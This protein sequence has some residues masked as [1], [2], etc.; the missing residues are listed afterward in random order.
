MDAFAVKLLASACMLVDHI[1]AVFYMFT[2]AF[3]RW[4][5]RISM[6]LYV[7]LIAQGCAKTG[8]INRY[9][10]RLGVFALLS[11]IPFDLAFWQGYYI[12]E[13]RPPAI[14]FLTNT[15]IFYT[16]FFG[17]ACVNVYENARRNAGAYKIF[18]HSVLI[19]LKLR[20]HEENRYA[21]SFLPVLLFTVLF[22]VA[23]FCPIYPKLALTF[24]ILS[25]ML[26]SLF[27]WPRI[28]VHFNVT[29]EAPPES[30]RLADDAAPEIGAQSTGAISW[31]ALLP[32]LPLFTM[33][34]T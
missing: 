11:E 20:P 12:E 16:L 26:F 31:P 6:P 24:V 10:C 18:V 25:H 5:G 7:Y 23:I 33:G 13:G 32:V 21:V 15:N 2:P 30:E 22:F 28:F 19:K 14:D 8:N 34:D 9:M 29:C 17:V 27:A 1:G 3:F 4:I